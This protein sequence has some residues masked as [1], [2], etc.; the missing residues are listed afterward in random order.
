MANTEK[1][2]EV[3]L[4]SAPKKAWK[5]VIVLAAIPTLIGLSMMTEKLA[6]PKANHETV[7]T[8]EK[9]DNEERVI[10]IRLLGFNRPSEAVDLDRFEGGWHYRFEGPPGTTAHFG[11]GFSGPLTTEWGTRGGKVRFTGPRGQIVTV[12][13]YP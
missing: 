3:K 5:V 1:T 8:V 12:R 7:E 6:R 2:P 11:S 9:A 10:Q 4:G 13:V